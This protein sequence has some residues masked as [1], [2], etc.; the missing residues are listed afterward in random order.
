MRLKFT[1]ILL[2]L[3]LLIFGLIVYLGKKT[4]AADSSL[5]GLSTLIGSEVMEADRIELRGSGLDRPRV[6]TR[7][8]NDWEIT[9][10][11]RWKANYF[12]VNR[13][14]NQLQFIEEEASFSVNEI[15]STGQTLADYGLE[16]PLVEL[17]ISEGDESIK[18]S[19]GT[20]LTEI[21]N[22][23]YLL[24]PEGERVY[25]VGREIVESIPLNLDDLRDRDIFDIPVFEVT[26]LSVQIQSSDQLDTGGLKVR[27]ANTAGQWRFEAPLSADAD[28]ALVSNT[29]NSLASL[30]A[31]RF[32]EPDVSDPI[33]QG[34]ER[35]FMRITLHGN[36]RRQTLLIGNPDSST[37]PNGSQQFFARLEGNPVAF[38][39]DARPFQNLLQAQESLRERNF[40]TFE[41]EE[42]NSIYIKESGREIR[43]QKIETGDWQVLISYGEGQIQPKR[44]DPEVMQA[45]ITDLEELRAQ[46][47]TLDAPNNV[48]LDQLGFSEARRT[49]T[50]GFDTSDP[51]VLELAHPEEENR[52]LYARTSNK[53][54][55]YEVER[56][57]TLQLFPLNKLHYRNRN[58]ETLPQAALIR[59]LTLSNR[60]SGETIMS[61]QSDPDTGWSSVLENLPAQE[62]GA[63]SR[64]LGFLRKADVKSYLQDGFAES[65][66]LDPETELPWVYELSA[67]VILPGGDTEQRRQLNYVFTDRLSGTQQIGGSPG[68]ATIFELKLEMIEAL[69]LLTDTRAL[70]PE[71]KGEPVPST[72]TPTPL[73]EPEPLDEPEPDSGLKTEIEAETAE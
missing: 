58:I 56:R 65:Y 13:I 19:V 34:L 18:L 41:R 8:G 49:I 50:L 67:E 17:I 46:A 22:N 45:L 40:M 38:T 59:S 2:V 53:R 43:L 63:A 9:E 23:I 44:A 66:Q 61:Y 30:K 25:V 57:A 68:H 36:K 7:S 73:P 15:L 47:F 64:L 24:G 60:Q 55:I 52:K 62:A 69:Y 32:I 70:P 26:E 11:T 51:L 6:L 72:P 14:L 27:L 4:D 3:N 5:A 39:V 37:P 71:A 12:A 54:S 33:I 29:I 31:G 16:E 28:P 20:Q 42:L 10:P 21:G 1:L 48:D 35:P